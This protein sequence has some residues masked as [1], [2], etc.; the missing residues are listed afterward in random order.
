MRLVSTLELVGEGPLPVSVDWGKALLDWLALQH[1]PTGEPASPPPLEKTSANVSA[2]LLQAI[3]AIGHRHGL[4]QSA[5]VAGVGDLLEELLLMADWEGASEAEEAPESWPAE[6]N[7]VLCIS[8]D[9]V[10]APHR[11]LELERLTLCY[12]HDW[13]GLDRA[14]RTIELRRGDGAYVTLRLTPELLA[15][16]GPRRLGDTRAVLRGIFAAL[17]EALLGTPMSLDPTGVAWIEVRSTGPQGLPVMTDPRRP[18]WIASSWYAWWWPLFEWLS[19][20]ADR[21]QA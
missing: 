7:P 11:L 6:W 19:T 13:R 16:A 15:K 12:P 2:D 17:G 14:E 3:D 10:T 4:S 1:V 8:D 21:A 18:G 9:A 5:L 20:N